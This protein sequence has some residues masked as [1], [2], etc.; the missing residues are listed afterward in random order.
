MP[1]RFTDQP[2]RGMSDGGAEAGEVLGLECGDPA[3]DITPEII[4]RFNASLI[5]RR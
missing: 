2:G 3:L 4:A 1:D 5:S